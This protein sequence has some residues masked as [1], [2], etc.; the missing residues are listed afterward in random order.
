MSWFDKLN[1]RLWAPKLTRL[2][3]GLAVV[4]A[5]VADALQLPTQAVPPAP[6]VIDVIAMVLTVGLLGFHLLLLPTFLV[7]FIPM[8][9]MLPTWT[10]CVIA[11]IALRKREQADRQPVIEVDPAPPTPPT[12][13]AERALPPR[14]NPPPPPAHD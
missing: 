5:L 3:I 7:E 8:V 6:E 10:G 4:V 2:R 11:V 12:P 14:I 9:D 13:P 1:G